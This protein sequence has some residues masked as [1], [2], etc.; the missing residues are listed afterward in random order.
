MN[1][2]VRLTV[3]WPDSVWE[4]AT[5]REYLIRCLRDIA[6]EIEDR[7]DRAPIRANN[8]FQLFRTP[9]R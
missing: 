2:E 3:F 9:I 6:A 7:G 8:V 4:E 5:E 1:N